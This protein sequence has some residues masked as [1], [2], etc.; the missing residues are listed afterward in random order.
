MAIRR[1]FLT[2]HRAGHLFMLA[3]IVLS[4]SACGQDTSTE[5]SSPEDST[6]PATPGFSQRDSAGILI[7]VTE[8]SSAS[9]PLD[10]EVDSVPDLVLGTSSDPAEQFFRIGGMKGLSE[11]G[12]VVVDGSSRELRFFNSFG[13][14]QNRV[15]RKGEG[16]GEFDDPVLVPTVE[17]DSL[18]IWDTGLKRFQVFSNDGQDHRTVLLRERWP[19]GGRS[20]VGAVDHQHM[21]VRKHQ[22][23]WFAPAS[24]QTTG[25]KEDQVDYFWYDPTAGIETSIV[26]VPVMRN[27]IYVRNGRPPVMDLIPFAADPSSAVTLDGVLLAHGPD[28]EVHKFDLEGRLRL[29]FR[30]EELSRPVTPEMIE[31]HID[32][33]LSAAQSASSR[34]FLRELFSQMP[35]PDTLPAFQSLQVDEVGWLWAELYARD[36]NSPKQWMIFDPE[37]RAHGTIETPGGLDV[38]SIGED[39]ILGVWLDEFGVE[40]VR[41]HSLRRVSAGR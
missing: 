1:V 17:S 15:G 21:L 18:L 4:L 19:A 30:V 3:F 32:R 29:I 25:A 7:S 9:A 26:S 13:L 14:L 10:W 23:V 6:P 12:V 34:D 38:Q 20:P 36:P 35:I 28:P 33:R 37:G 11:G 8:G 16:P 2:C 5:D 39:F 24:E 41:R 31:A 27:F 22:A 40:Q